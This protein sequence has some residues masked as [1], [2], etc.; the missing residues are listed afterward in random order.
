[1]KGCSTYTG[2]YFVMFKRIYGED[3][4]WMENYG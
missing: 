4:C 2:I 3:V 1:M